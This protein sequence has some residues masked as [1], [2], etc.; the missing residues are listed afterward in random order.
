M[1]NGNGMR[2][3]WRPGQVR[4]VVPRTRPVA[5]NPL[6]GEPETASGIYDPHIQVDIAQFQQ[7]R[8]DVYPYGL[9]QPAPG[10]S[11]DN[12]PGLPGQPGVPGVPALPPAPAPGQVIEPDRF[13]RTARTPYALTT[14]TILAIAAAAPGTPRVFLTIRNHHT[15]A[16]NVYIDFDNAAVTPLIASYELVP[17]GIAFFDQFVPQGD[18]YLVSDSTALAVVVFANGP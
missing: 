8:G 2:R 18:L 14:T 15:S 5:V 16:G 13:H 4:L 1:A 17:Q 7:A 6:T 9:D 10:A 3:P 12:I 11:P